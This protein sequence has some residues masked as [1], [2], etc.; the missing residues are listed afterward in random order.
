MSIVKKCDIVLLVYNKKEMT[1]ECIERIN[2]FASPNERLIIVDNGSDKETADFLAS[3]D[4]EFTNIEIEVFRLEDNQGFVGGTN[5]GLKHSNAPYICMISNDVLVTSSWIEEML[6]VAR[7]DDK[8]GIV[9]PNSNNYNCYPR[10]KETIDDFS[11]FLKQNSVPV[12]FVHYCVGFCMLLKRELI[13]KIGYLD[14]IYSPGYF[15]DNDYCRRAA[16]AGFRSA[17]AM[18]AYAWHKE[19]ATFSSAERQMQFEKNKDVFHERWGK[20]KRLVL[21]ANGKFNDELVDKALDLAANGDWVKLLLSKKDDQYKKRLSLH[22]AIKISY[23]PKFSM[24]PFAFFWI[25]KKRKKKIDQIYT[26]SK[27]NRL[28]RFL[29]N[30]PVKEL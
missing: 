1:R 15:E 12:S 16:A 4:S 19:H 29:L 2:C 8:I 7:S 5:F 11:E 26:I 28:W 9:G 30:R 17:L 25:L 23:M 24:L 21:V 18:R 10:D 27:I 6:N 3:C 13:E 20:P 22:S 14:D